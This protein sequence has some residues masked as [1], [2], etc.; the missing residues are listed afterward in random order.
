[1]VRIVTR[2]TD[3][4]SV[5]PYKEIISDQWTVIA[6]NHEVIYLSAKNTGFS[7][8]KKICAMAKQ[9][10]IL[11]NGLFSFYFS[12]LPLFLSNYYNSKKTFVAVRG[13]L[14]GSALAVKPLKKQMFLAFARGFGLYKKVTMLSTSEYEREEIIK[15]L[16]KVKIAFA[17]NLP[18]V[19]TMTN[20]E[21][22]KPFKGTNGELRLLFL[23]RISPE[24]NPVAVIMALK[25]VSFPVSIHF[26]GSSIN[27]DYQALFEK[28][29]SE[30]PGNIEHHWIKELPHERIQ[31]QFRTTDVMILPSH[32]ENFGHAIFESLANAVPVIIG[33]NT[34]WKGIQEKKAGIEVCSDD[35]ASIVSAILFM[36]GLSL[37]EYNSWKQGA[38]N[39]AKEYYESG[40]FEN[41]YLK[42]LG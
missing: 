27:S 37:K 42:L 26:I 4:G 15:S 18:V 6:P 38:L 31:Q 32:G 33:D 29:L 5:E 10:I 11:I 23:G 8:I 3:Y 40:N 19:P 24:K 21:P 12:V 16:G 9:D 20:P 41:V 22:E 25:E 36:Y 17:P 14:H 7:N 35:I 39:T 13:M 1:M 28:G 2:N 30:L 34:P